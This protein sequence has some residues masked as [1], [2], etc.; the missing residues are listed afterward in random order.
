VYNDS[1]NQVTDPP[2]DAHPDGVA[3]IFP[4]SDDDLSL[5]PKSV[6]VGKDI[7]L[8]DCAGVL[9]GNFFA[10]GNIGI[11]RATQIVER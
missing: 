11:I 2:T 3:G 1:T 8:V 7:Q 9:E 4:T 5:T 6:A 10:N